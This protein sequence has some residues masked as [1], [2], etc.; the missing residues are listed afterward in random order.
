MSSLFSN[1]SSNSLFSKYF[2]GRRPVLESMEDE[3]HLRVIRNSPLLYLNPSTDTLQLSNAGKALVKRQQT[4]KQDRET[5]ASGSTGGTASG[6]FPSASST[7]PR[8]LVESTPADPS[9]LERFTV[10]DIGFSAVLMRGIYMVVE[11]LPAAAF[12]ADIIESCEQEVREKE[13][14]AGRKNTCI[15]ADESPSP[16]SHPAESVEMHR[17]LQFNIHAKNGISPAPSSSNVKIGEEPVAGFKPRSRSPGKGSG[18]GTKHRGSTD[19]PDGGN[20][21]WRGSASGSDGESSSD[22][23]KVI[24]SRRKSRPSSPNRSKPT[25]G[26]MLGEL[27]PISSGADDTPLVSSTASK[28]APAISDEALL[29]LQ[30][31]KK[32][33][34]D[35]LKARIPPDVLFLKMCDLDPE[36]WKVIYMSR[37]QARYQ[38]P[39]FIVVEEV[40]PLNE[41][42]LSKQPGDLL[43]LSS[44]D[45]P[46]SGAEGCCAA[47]AGSGATKETVVGVNRRK[48]TCLVIRGTKEFKDIMTD[49]RGQNGFQ[50]SAD[51]I[52]QKLQ[53]TLT[54]GLDV[55]ANTGEESLLDYLVNSPDFLII[56]HSLGAAVAIRIFRRLLKEGKIHDPGAIESQVSARGPGEFQD[57]DPSD[58][59]YSGDD[60][61]P[62]VGFSRPISS[63]PTASKTSGFAPVRM[64]RESTASLGLPSTTRVLVFGC[65]P[66]SRKDTA[67]QTSSICH[68]I[69]GFDM[70]SRMSPR[71]VWRMGSRKK[72]YKH[73]DNCSPGLGA[74]QILKYYTLPSPEE[75]EKKPEEKP[76]SSGNNFASTTDLLDDI[77]LN[78]NL[79]P[80]KGQLV[81]ERSHTDDVRRGDRGEVDDEKGKRRSVPDNV[82]D[83]RESDWDLFSA[84]SDE[85]AREEPVRRFEARL[86]P[87]NSSAFMWLTGRSKLIFGSLEKKL[88]RPVFL[89]T[90]LQTMGPTVSVRSQSVNLLESPGGS[91]SDPSQQAVTQSSPASRLPSKDRDRSPSLLGV[92]PKPSIEQSLPGSF[93]QPD[94]LPQFLMDDNTDG[95]IYFSRTFKDHFPRETVPMFFNW[96]ESQSERR[97]GGPDAVGSPFKQPP[98][99]IGNLWLMGMLRD[100]KS[101]QWEP[102]PEPG[103]NGPKED[104]E[105]VSP[106]KRPSKIRDDL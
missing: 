1:M 88:Q 11:S 58:T 53:S 29:A 38:K 96:F 33:M 104:L 72:F 14:Q 57:P 67:F 6:L 77:D 60:D 21:N 73:V 50:N 99:L 23:D 27:E 49:I 3:E 63:S 97:F 20:P 91:D 105:A 56:G 66:V 75:S 22:L 102:P 89:E 83:R 41:V 31:R 17:V 8:D 5:Q 103:R 92:E 42:T 74:I 12:D 26:V 64:I 106:K 51:Y 10:S 44:P 2:L 28:E 55:A 13:R 34:S 48:R 71:T 4:L 68:I 78:F 45:S 52:Y 87:R 98:K 18:K 80:Q 69:T 40:V 39:V 59:P 36:R 79:P 19:D 101:K 24:A 46:D 85:E 9:F 37:A 81:R 35:A 61:G 43:E 65:P 16:T 95:K 47:S 70:F 82:L 100:G 94:P 25:T 30:T 76:S 32:L 62:G 7:A 84:I 93:S 86:L 90:D 15:T 54:A